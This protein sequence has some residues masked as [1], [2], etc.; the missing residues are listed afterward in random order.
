MSAHGPQSKHATAGLRVEPTAIHWAVVDGTIDRPVLV[1]AKTTSAPKGWDEPARLNWYRKE[2]T[3][4]LNLYQPRRLAVRDAEAFGP[5]GRNKSLQDRARIEGVAI[6]LAYSLGVEV[7]S[8]A[9]KTISARLGSKAGKKHIAEDDLRGLDWS[10]YDD[11]QREAIM[12]A[13]SLLEQ[14]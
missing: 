11:K 12:S 14:Q 3:R 6:E 13:A 4:I 5:K 8:G 9:M 1:D 7:Q 10:E 2:L